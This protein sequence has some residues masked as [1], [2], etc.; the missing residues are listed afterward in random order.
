[1]GSMPL[2]AAAVKQKMG[3]LTHR[4]STIYTQKWAAAQSKWWCAGNAPCTIINRHHSQMITSH[5]HMLAAAQEPLQH[6]A[7]RMA[8]LSAM[9]GAWLDTTHN[10]LD[11]TQRSDL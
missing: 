7:P 10:R 3:P 4:L 8:V 5:L 2:L 6:H 1:M 9:Y 11:T